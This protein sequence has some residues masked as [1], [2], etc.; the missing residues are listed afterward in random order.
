MP[1]PPP[2]TIATLPFE[3]MLGSSVNSSSAAK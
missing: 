1:L 2:V 3:A